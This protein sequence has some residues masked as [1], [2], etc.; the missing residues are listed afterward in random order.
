MNNNKL[1][2]NNLS[3][4]QILVLMLLAYAFSFTIRMIWVSWASQNPSFFWNGELMINTNDG[5][6]F[7]STTEYL[8]SGLHANNPKVQLASNSYL[9]LQYITYLFTKY[10]PFSLNTVILYLPSI[11][12][13]LIVIPIILTGK[14]LK[15]PWVGFFSALLGSI[16]WSYYNRTMVGYY[17]SDMFAIFLQFTIFYLFLSTIYSKKDTNILWLSIIL[18]LYPI[19]YPQGMTITYALFFFW[20]LYQL[21]FQREERNSYFFIIIASI[22]LWVVAIWIKILL[23]LGLF[24][25][26]KQVKHTLDNK[27][28]LYLTLGTLLLFLFLSNSFGLIWKMINLYLARGVEND[29][30]NFYQV[31]QTVREAGKISWETI[32]NRIIGHPIL[33]L[34]SLIGYIMLVIKNKPFILALPLIGVGIF[35]HWAGLRFTVYAVAISAFS[36]T[37]LLYIISQYIKN[38]KLSY[39]FFVTLFLFALYPNISHIIGYKVPTVLN[40]TEVQDLVK[41]N[42]IANE[43]DYTLAWWD[44][45]YPIWYYSDTSTLIDGGKHQND[46]FIISQIMQ[47]SSAEFATNLARLAV[48]TYVQSVDSYTHFFEEGENEEDIPEKFKMLDKKGDLYH[49]GKGSVIDVLLKNNQ[50]DQVNPEVF[51]SDLKSNN[52]TPPKKTRNIYLYLPYRMMNIF[53]TVAVFG[54]LDLT[55]GKPKRKFIFYPTSV[56]DNK[57]GIIVL[58]NGITFDAKKGLIHAGTDKKYVKNFIVTQNTQG[59]KT[60][61]QSKLYHIDGTHAVIYMKSYGRFVVMDIETFHSVYVQMFILGKYDKNFFEL[62]VS[63]PYSKIYKFRK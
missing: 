26:F 16:A 29:G 1:D 6:Y 5:Y 63:S 61:L 43:K 45:G 24:I 33:L 35:A 23:I 34:F 57:N 54:N 8:L 14:L 39:A 30:L 55:T 46:N 60:N 40:A 19:F 9:G 10:T 27:K 20:V 3:T 50:R 37:Y 47:T 7:A 31:I 15:L 2:I 18:L 13:S 32:S 49:A 59:E 44:Y 36:F 52:Y 51:L 38:K 53:P 22:A 42:K 28:F 56:E 58:K 41:L 4:K 25:L 12:S 21:L 48:E 62:V 17:D 11:I